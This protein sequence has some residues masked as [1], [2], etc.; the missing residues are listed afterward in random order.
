M[1]A[2]HYAIPQWIHEMLVGWYEGLSDCNSAEENF[3]LVLYVYSYFSNK[4]TSLIPEACQG[5]RVRM[6]C[7]SYLESPDLFRCNRLRYEGAK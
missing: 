5:A 6:M 1:P 2:L 4:E 7:V 3:R